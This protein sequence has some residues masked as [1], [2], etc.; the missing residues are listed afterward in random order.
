[1]IKT[2]GLSHR[3]VGRDNDV[4]SG[5]IRHYADARIGETRNSDDYVECESNDWLNVQIFGGI[6]RF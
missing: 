4:L 6:E 2:L 5:P 1:M 3:R